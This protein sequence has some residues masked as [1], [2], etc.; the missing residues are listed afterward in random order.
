MGRS[1]RVEGTRE[2][3]ITGTPFI[4]AYPKTR[5]YPNPGRPACR[6]Q[7]AKEILAIAEFVV[8]TRERSETG[9]I[10]TT[11]HEMAGFPP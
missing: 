6:P 10:P 1:G 4:V 2:L 5:R 11:Y 8:P 9:G 7:V 3:V